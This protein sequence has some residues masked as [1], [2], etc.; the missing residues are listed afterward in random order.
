MYFK[1]V[2]VTQKGGFLR[3]RYGYL[4]D[5]SLGHEGSCN[6]KLYMS[7][8]SY[9]YGEALAKA[10]KIHSSHVPYQ[11]EML[12]AEGYAPMWVYVD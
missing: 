4:P 5:G 3:Y 7:E 2:E 9:S 10:H 11:Q 12:Y 1:C 8:P 6:C